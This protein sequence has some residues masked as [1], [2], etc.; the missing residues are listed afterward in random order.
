MKKILASSSQH[1][2]GS[3]SLEL[4]G[5]VVGSMSADGVIDVR[6]AQVPMCDKSGHVILCAMVAVPDLMGLV[7]HYI[8]EYDRTDQLIWP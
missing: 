7:L 3:T 1:L 8:E 2:K 5:H 4:L 6:S